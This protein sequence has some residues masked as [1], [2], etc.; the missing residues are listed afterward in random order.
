MNKNTKNKTKKPQFFEIVWLETHSSIIKAKDKK[1][2]EET[3]YDKICKKEF[4]TDE[5]TEINSNTIEVYKTEKPRQ[6]KTY[7]NKKTKSNN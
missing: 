2:A 7:V 4:I 1:E 6:I 5:E 3:A